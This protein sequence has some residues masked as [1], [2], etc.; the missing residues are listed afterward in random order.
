MTR[1]E[2]LAELRAQIARA[3]ERCRETFGDAGR[4]PWGEII[5]ACW[6][7]HHHVQELRELQSRLELLTGSP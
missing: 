2:R 4:C 1:D 6:G 3:R 7:Y 5:F